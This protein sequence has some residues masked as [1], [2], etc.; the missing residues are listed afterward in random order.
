[1]RLIAYP[2]HER[3][4]IESIKVDCISVPVEP[5]N[6]E[7]A[8]GRYGVLELDGKFEIAFFE[9]FESSECSI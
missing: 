7:P 6:S 8:Q 4:V 5:P 9:G 1:V 3:V 2:N